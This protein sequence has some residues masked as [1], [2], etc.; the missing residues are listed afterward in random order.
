KQAF[1]VDVEDRVVELLGDRAQGR[2][3]RYTGIG[4]DDVEPTLLALDLGEQAIEIVKVR[5]ISSDGGDVAPD[6]LDRRRQLGLTPAGD[7]AVGRFV[8][9]LPGRRQANATITT[10]NECNFSF[11]LAHVSSPCLT[12][13]EPENLRRAAR[14]AG[15]SCA[16]A[17]TSA[18]RNDVAS[19]GVDDGS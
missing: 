13:R 7:E 12:F 9:E 17:F 14:C 8:D 3:L 10:G 2:K 11:D 19:N 5:H 18:S 15:I 1:H 4:E 16:R 6:L